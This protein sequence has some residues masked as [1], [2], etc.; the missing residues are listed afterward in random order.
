MGWGRVEIHPG[1]FLS[2][3]PSPQD[4]KGG[5][6]PGVQPSDSGRLDLWEQVRDLVARTGARGGDG[7]LGMRSKAFPEVGHFPR[8]MCVLYTLPAEI[9]G[10]GLHVHPGLAE[11]VGLGDGWGQLRLWGTSVF[12]CCIAPSSGVLLAWSPPSPPP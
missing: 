3:P 8:D 6:T 2:S 5:T 1:P 4:S 12:A 10:N 7:V 11:P 9:T